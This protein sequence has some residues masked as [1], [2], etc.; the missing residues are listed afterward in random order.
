MPTCEHDATV[1]LNLR[2]SAASGLDY[3]PPAGTIYEDEHSH[4]HF[5]RPPDFARDC[6]CERRE[7]IFAEYSGTSYTSHSSAS[8]HCRS[9]GLFPQQESRQSQ[10]RF[11]C[12]DS[13]GSTTTMAAS[14]SCFPSAAARHLRSAAA[15]ACHVPSVNALLQ[16][17]PEVQRLRANLPLSAVRRL[18]L[19]TNTV[20]PT[21]AHFP[22]RPQQVRTGPNHFPQ[23]ARYDPHRPAFQ[24]S[25]GQWTPSTG[26][27]YYQPHSWNPNVFSVN[28]EQSPITT[29][30][31]HLLL[32]RLS[33]QSEPD[34][35]L[36][37]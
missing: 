11:L 7:T 32:L 37:P 34:N 35:P 9:T 36:S 27:E 6:N 31:Q 25:P 4:G 22:Q 20:V 13:F 16:P 1:S 33:R 29:D 17:R 24:Q 30:P 19:V 10:G 26:Y 14:G 2:C 8:T 28:T 5:T 15:T 18:S 3:F 12:S 21:P 23:N